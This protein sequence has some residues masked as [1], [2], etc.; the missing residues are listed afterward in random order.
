[1][2]FTHMQIEFLRISFQISRGKK[3]KQFCNPTSI[4]NEWIYKW[5]IFFLSPIPSFEILEK[6]IWRER[7]L[8][9]KTR[10]REMHF[11]SQIIHF[12][13]QRNWDFWF[14]GLGTRF[15]FFFCLFLFE[16]SLVCWERTREQYLDDIWIF[17]VW[18]SSNK[19]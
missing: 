13:L 2:I 1:M 17:S 9:N 11:E 19:F 15:G 18:I 5:E 8:K 12:W 14:K 10:V 7:E 3:R 6:P 16:F 4:Q